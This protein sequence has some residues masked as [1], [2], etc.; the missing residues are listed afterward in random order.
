MPSTATDVR[1]RA[2]PGFLGVVLSGESVAIEPKSEGRI[3]TLRVHAGDRVAQGAIIAELDRTV[4]DQDVRSARAALADASSRFAR[5]AAL[6]RGPDPAVTAE[7]LDTARSQL[8][9]ERARVAAVTAALPETQ[10]V[11]PFEGT[12]AEIYLAPGALA[13]PG[14]AV[15]RVVSQG[16]LQVRFAMPEQGAAAVVSGVPIDVEI[17]SLGLRARGTVTG[18]NPEVDASSRMIFAAARLDVA[19]D[20]ARRLTTGLVARVRP[21][22]ITPLEAPPFAASLER[23]PLRAL[24]PPPDPPAPPSVAEE[25]AQAPSELSSAPRVRAR[26]PRGSASAMSRW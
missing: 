20:V 7:E 17:G 25:N 9:Q 6:A 2:D 8:T 4:R 11:A 16:Q 23:A 21:A 19:D 5:R 14:R 15:A 12:V 18:V 26:R 3:M 24:A 13:G 10:V 22:P 1:L